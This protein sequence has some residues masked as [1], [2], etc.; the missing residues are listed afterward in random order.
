M[1]LL[2]NYG[3]FES[4]ISI[5]VTILLIFFDYKY[6]EIGFK[7]GT[8]PEQMQFMAMF[9]NLMGLIIVSLPIIV[10]RF[11]MIESVKLKKFIDLPVEDTPFTFSTVSSFLGEQAL[12]SFLAT[13]LIF[14]G[15]LAILEYGIF[16]GALYMVILFIIAICIAVISLTRFVSFFSQYSP[17]IYGFAAIASSCIV[18]AFVNVGLKMGA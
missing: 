4:G 14:T 6:I 13:V 10:R 1:S 18:F 12:A 11:E 8:F 15:K 9:Y 17:V 7:V 16:F 2:G 5:I 3:K